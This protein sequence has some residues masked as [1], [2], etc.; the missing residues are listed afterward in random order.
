MNNALSGSL[1]RHADC[2]GI[3]LVN[4]SLIARLQ[5]LVEL[6]ESGLILGSNDAVAQVLLL[7]DLDALDS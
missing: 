6:F 1:V 2:I 3:S 7:G 4:E 5:R